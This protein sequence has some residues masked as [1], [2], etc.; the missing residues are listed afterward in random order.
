VDQRKL[1]ID[2]LVMLAR[3]PDQGANLLTAVRA[4]DG[5]FV[6]TDSH[7]EA[8]RSE[9]EWIQKAITE[10]VKQNSNLSKFFEHIHNIIKSRLSRLGD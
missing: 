10:R 1:L 4:I 7:N 6:L 5:H 3:Q 2:A 8:Q 9:L